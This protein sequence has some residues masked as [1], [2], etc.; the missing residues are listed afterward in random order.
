MALFNVLFD[1]AAQDTSFHSSIDRIERRFQH[2]S[3]V[4]QQV[5][6]VLGV[7]FTVRGIEQFIMNNIRA[8]DAMEKA[9]V[10]AGVAVSV[11]SQL[12]Y[13]A[14]QSGISTEELSL[15]FKNM[16]VAVS[17]GD[18]IK[19]F[20]AIGISIKALRQLKPEDQLEAIAEAFANTE[21]PATRARAATELFGRAGF[22]MIPFLEKG[23]AGIA[24][25][26]K[27]ADDLGITLDEF[28][29]HAAVQADEA[30]KKMEASAASLGR[31]LALMVAPG[32]TRFADWFRIA[33]GGG[34]PTEDME[35]YLGQLNAQKKGMESAA[36]GNANGAMVDQKAYAFLNEEIAR[37]VVTLGKLRA[38]GL[39]GLPN[40][41]DVLKTPEGY[42]DP[43]AK[44]KHV[45]DMTGA[46]MNEQLRLMDD[47][48]R[49]QDEAARY[50]NETLAADYQEGL[51]SLGD[52]SAKRLAITEQN[53]AAVQ[54]IYIREIATLADFIATSKDRDQQII[55]SGKIQQIQ[56][57]MAVDR[58][59]ASREQNAIDRETS[60]EQRDL[61]ET[62]MSVEAAYA[63]MNGETETAN[64]LQTALQDN[65]LKLKLQSEGLL[66]VY[67]KLLEVEK[68]RAL[69][70][71]RTA[72]A[73]VTRAAKEYMKSL[74][75]VA[76]STARITTDMFKGIED[77]MT[78]WI[79]TGKLTFR[80]FIDSMI[81]DLARFFVQQSIMKP[82]IESLSGGGGGWLSAIFGGLMGSPS[83]SGDLYTRSGGARAGGG[84][85]YPGSTYLV[86]ERGPEMFR[87]NSAGSII[88]NGAGG[89]SIVYSPVIN[90]DS[91]AD[92]AQVQADVQ[93]T[94]R[95]GNRQLVAMLQRYNRGL[96]T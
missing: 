77:A 63:A 35:K 11:F 81:A 58:S 4:V 22:N 72:G 91:R 90:I 78:S 34:S 73:G 40:L 93:R 43:L 47:Q 21:D 24:A 2:L 88:P 61:A 83:P 87:P 12:D 18:T 67:D 45:K 68:N 19:A 17:K 74:E 75:D 27:E 6:S 9:S 15:A 46:L 28:S 71:D 92:R 5:G 3:G 25:L 14:K 20:S 86:G 54:D 65:T 96:R 41:T 60:R 76:S 8:A 13:A 36:R 94:V 29:A 56:N 49:A 69:Y 42:T 89:Q 53:S 80:S 33:I 50:L 48:I 64:A 66:D 38:M 59:R 16:E 79:T 26:R 44:A 1:I 62:I 55:A 51:V 7:A 37:T 30:F 82:L 52:Y 39:K 23:A 10:K 31:R 32:V 57:D 95:E 84:S 70:A 85:V